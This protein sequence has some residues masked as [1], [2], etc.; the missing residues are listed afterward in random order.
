MNLDKWRLA[1]EKLTTHVDETKLRFTSTEEVPPLDGIVGQ[2]RALKSIEFGTQIDSFGYNLYVLGAPGTGRASAV[3]LALE[4]RARTRPKADDWCY[5]NNYAENH[6]PITIRLPAGKGRDFRGD[7]EELIKELGRQLPQAFEGEHY[8]NQRDK[9]NQDLQQVQSYEFSML[10]RRAR[11]KGFVLQ[12]AG[13]MFG[14]VPVVDGQPI[15]PEDYE[16]LDETKRREIEEK[17]KELREELNSAVKRVRDAE[18]QAKNRVD[19]LSRTVANFS[20]GHLIEE[21]R[22]KYRPFPRVVKY[23]DDTQNDIVENVQLFLQA[24]QQEQ[25][26]AMLG[27]RLPQQPQTDVFDRY[28]VNLL[29]DNFEQAGAPVVF[30]TNPTY[31][32]LLGRIEHK[33]QF[34]TMLT[35]FTM[36]KAGSLHRANGGYLVIEARDLLTSFLSYDAL[37]RS[38][39]NQRIKIEEISEMFRLISTVTLEPEPV[40]LDVKV[41][42]IGEPIIY[43]LLYAYDQDFSKLFKVKADFDSL[44]DRTE[45]SEM[46]YARFIGKRCREEKI[47]QFDPSGVAEVLR[48]G[49]RLVEDQR[50]FTARLL[51][52]NDILREASFWA[53]ANGARLVAAADVKRAIHE[54]EYRSN[55]IEERIREMIRDGTI[56]IDTEGGVVGQVNGLSIMQLGDYYFGRPS[57]IT[58]RTFMGRGGVVNIEREARMSG[59]IHN[60]GVLILTGYLAGKF[61]HER[62]LSVAAS[63]TF[64]QSYEGVEGDSASSAELYC[65]LSSLAGV[66]IRQDVALTGSVNQLGQIQPIGGVT[67]KIEGF[68]DVCR[69]KGLTGT[70]GVMIPRTNEPNLVLKDEVIEA[71]CEGKFHIYSVASI[72]EG[73]AVLMGRE[74]GELQPDGTYP[75]GTVF[76]AVDDA[77]RAMTEKL[78]E[79]AAPREK[80]EELLAR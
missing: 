57:R 10:Q 33:A 73:I 27:M 26:Q 19:D 59:R 47:K 25:A 46:D 11:E 78:A 60:K 3:R 24:G 15:D 17:G 41:V 36:I 6:K 49:T 32:N 67:R 2:D 43:Y 54:K 72:E 48:Y 64:E 51:D 13:G 61:A 31:Y 8:R 21:L 38:L 37:K 75:E 79:L 68:F 58:A 63:I 29:V 77:L 18:K 39:R 69:I 12:Q 55:R 28:E 40:P 23:L 7:M 30:E 14:I 65:L 20:V 45:S 44:V 4:K 52:I 76:R 62:P 5:V 71:V 35:D 22:S 34:G 74:A 1:P 70:Q 50:K 16:K 80:A 9:V 53:G 66:P 56:M 42:I